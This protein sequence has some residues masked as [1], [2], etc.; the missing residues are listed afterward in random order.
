MY[1]A[2][3]FLCIVAGCAGWG[4]SL[5][6]R[7]QERVWHLGM[8]FHALGQIRSGISY[9]KHTMPEICLLLSE[10]DDECYSKCFEQIYKRTAG[11]NG[12]DFR[13]VWEEEMKNFLKPLPLQEDEK[14]TVTDL[15]KYL[16]FREAGGQ[17][18]RVG[19]AEAFLEGRY[20][21]AEESCVNRSKMI[22]SVSILTG[23]LLAILLL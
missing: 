13:K 8:L 14:R 16:G 10:S 3:G 15:A 7:E 9:G 1:K 21:K 12:K 2:V 4:N 20:R 6:Q 23:L 19:Q 18:G 5:A 22:H 11:E 17:A